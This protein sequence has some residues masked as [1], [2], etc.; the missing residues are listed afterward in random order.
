M[1][2]T[3][4]GKTKQIPSSCWIRDW[5]GRGV[6]NK[7]VVVRGWGVGVCVCGGGA[8]V[9]RFRYPTWGGGG[10]EDGFFLCKKKIRAPHTTKEI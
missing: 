2:E 7:G 6:L 4:R 8:S 9:V 1:G 10:G 3:R 5:R